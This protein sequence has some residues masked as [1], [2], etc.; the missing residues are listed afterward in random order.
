MEVLVEKAVDLEERS[1]TVELIAV[2]AMAECN[3]RRSDAESCD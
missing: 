1:E 3:R 2:V